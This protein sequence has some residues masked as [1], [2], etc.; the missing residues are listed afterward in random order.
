MVESW[1]LIICKQVFSGLILM[2]FSHCILLIYQKY[3]HHT[4]RRGG[5][6]KGK[7]MLHGRK[8]HIG[9]GNYSDLPVNLR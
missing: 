7:N 3:L 2:G 4:Y 1:P 8:L 6:K 9:W 5:E